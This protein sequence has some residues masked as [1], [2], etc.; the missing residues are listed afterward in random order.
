MASSLDNN[1]EGLI[2]S[3]AAAGGR[4]LPVLVIYGANASGKSNLIS[5][6]SFMRNAVLYSHNRG[7]PDS[8]I[9]RAPF[10]L[11]AATAKTPSIFDIDFI[12]E[13]TR[14][15]YGFEASDEAF[16]EEW[17]SAFP[18]GR[19]QTLFER[20]GANFSFGRGLRGRNKL[21]SELTR[22]NSLY[23]SAAAQNDHE[24]LSKIS[25]FFRSIRLSSISDVR[26]SRG[27][28]GGQVDQRTIDFLS[29]LGTGVIDY[30]RTEREIPEEIREFSK[31]IGLLANFDDRGWA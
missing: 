15:H 5:A 10:L 28:A 12:V 13:G 26:L 21:I 11:N 18:N 17:L 1:A 23:V 22:A 27:P 8:K 7:E 9:P 31:E 29:K 4:L 20:K 14:Y 6:L 3:P 2:N 19:R 16:V 25:R 30:R 24:E